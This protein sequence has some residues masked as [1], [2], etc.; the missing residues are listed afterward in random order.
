MALKEILEQHADNPAHRAKFLIE[1]EI[2][3]GLEHPGIVPVYSLGH[4]DGGRPYY[5]MRFIQGENLKQAIEHFHT[6]EAL[7]AD[8]GARSIALRDL[9]RRF[10]D[11]CDAIEYAHSRGVLHRDIKPGNVIVGNFGETLV[12]DWGLAK[13]RGRSEAESSETS[14]NLTLSLSSG[15]AETLPGQA[16]GTPAF[17]SPEQAMGDLEHLGPASDVYSLGATLYSLLTGTIPFEGN[18]QDALRNVVE[19]RFPAPRA[20]DPTIDPALEAICLKAMAKSPGDR[21]ATSRALAEDIDRWSADEPVTAWREPWTVRLRRSLVRH[22]TLAAGCAAAAV[23]ALLAVAVVAGVERRSNQALAAK[24]LELSMANVR[25][26]RARERAEDNYRLARRAV[27]DYLTK[28]SQDRLINV[29]G[30]QPL[31]EKLLDSARRFYQ[32]FLDRQGDDPGLRAEAARSYMR[33]GEVA[34]LIESPARC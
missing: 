31:R 3:G 12:V 26:A 20:I 8:P 19:G 15:S 22:K 24:N 10:T 18:V 4:D 27:D 25:E 13:A 9:L 29:P 1:A 14:R 16:I 21:Y 6:N 32:E 30:L 28:V 23:V 2:T 34:D 17:M 11:V 5:A 33:M 7:K